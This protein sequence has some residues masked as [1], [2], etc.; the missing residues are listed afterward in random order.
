MKWAKQMGQ[1]CMAQLET[2]INFMGWYELFLPFSK[3]FPYLHSI[4]SPT[5]SLFFSVLHPFPNSA[6]PLI[7]VKS[8]PTCIM[9][10]VQA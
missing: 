5:K 6:T 8:V 2:C 3:H 9:E 7:S 10:E 1:C 4:H